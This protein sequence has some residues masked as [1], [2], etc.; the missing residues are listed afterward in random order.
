VILLASV[1]VSIW[2]PLALLPGA[3][4]IG[5]YLLLVIRV[6]RWRRTCGDQWWNAALYAVFLVG[7]KVPS[8]VGVAHFWRNRL[9]GRRSQLIEYKESLASR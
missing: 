9:R 1:V 2:R 4:V 5:A 8:L 3:A 7:G 6:Q